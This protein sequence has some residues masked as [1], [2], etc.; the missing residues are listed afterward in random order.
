MAK[1]T[2]RPK[3]GVEEPLISREIIKRHN[4]RPILFYRLKNLWMEVTSNNNF[5]DALLI[6]FAFVA[7]TTALPF[8]PAALLILLIILLFAATLYHPFLGLIMF[9]VLIVPPIMYQTPA[10]AWIFMFIISGSLILGY[11]YYRTLAFSYILLG[12]ALSPLGYVLSIP[13]LAFSVLIVGYRRGLVLGAIFV[14]GAVMFSAVMGIQNSAYIVYDGV[15]AHGVI[16]GSNSFLQYSVPNKPILHIGTFM[17]GLSSAYSSFTNGDVISNMS[18]EFGGLL[19]AL[20]YSPVGYVI[21]FLGTLGIIVAIDFFAVNS[22]S[23]YKGTKASL[24]VAAYALLYVAVSGIMGAHTMYILPAASFAIAPICFYM[25]ERQ[26][27]SPVKALEVRKQDVRLKFGDVFEDLM[28]E[29]NVESFDDIGNYDAVKR[30]LIDAVI[31]PLEEKGVAR[32]YNIKPVKGILFFGPPG[33]GKTMIMRALSKEIHGAFYQ[34]KASTLISAFPGETERLIANMFKTA[35]AHS[36][37]VLFI[38][39]IDSLAR[40]RESMDVSESH[41]QALTQLLTEMDGFAKSDHIIVVGAT[42]VPNLV[43]TALMRPGRMDRVIYMPLPDLNGRRKILELYLKKL[44]VANDVNIKELAEKT[45]RFSGADIKTLV[46]S[47]AQTIAKEATEEGKVLEITQADLMSAIR[48]TKPSTTLAQIDEYN[49]FRIDYERRMFQEGTVE[50]SEGT[51]MDD[52]V[53]LDDAKKAITEAI[54]IPLMH[55]D[56]IKR[57]DIKPINGMLLF[58]PPGT[59]KSM[60]MKAVGEEMKGVTVL[61]LRGSEIA[62][63]KTEDAVAQVKEVFNRAR[64]NVPSVIYIDE[65]DG[66]MPKRDTSSEGS[67]RL[68]NQMLEEM[69]GV[70][71]TAA[72]VVIAATNR[73]SALDPAVLRPGRMDKLIFVKPPN[74]AQRA[75]LFEMYLKN[76]PCDRDI[77]FKRL[78]SLAKGFTGADIASVCREAKTEALESTIKSGTEARITE[79]SVEGI[80][81]STKPSAPESSLSVFL[82]FFAKYGER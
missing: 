28:A 70:R 73:P 77:D 45:E 54:Q 8:Y 80:I 12:L 25:L 30:E 2:R 56:L 78:G 41:R 75:L 38:D 9:M 26:G 44:P 50:V 15:A 65:I 23:R 13:A 34:V 82:S 46:E 33:S 52:V 71:K 29:G 47:V 16:A 76:A 20:A 40:S 21:Q 22:R 61:E 19:S 81:D 57:Y 14:L 31:T 7:V 59:G 79:K 11:R 1:A 24:V 32:A 39:E 3:G 35:K 72:I 5:L 4:I 6:F 74:E 36:P 27:V 49:K 10:L 43:D 42:N 17:A 60:L 62:N 67:Q 66:I 53:G 69:D 58:G 64:E 68:T 63:L 51:S 37:A 48:H 55:P 18:S